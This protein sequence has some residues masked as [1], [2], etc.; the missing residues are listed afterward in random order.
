MTAFRRF[1]IVVA[2]IVQVLS[3]IFCTL[4]GGVFGSASGAFRS[5]LFGV[6]TGGYSGI[7]IDGLGQIASTGAVLGFIIGAIGG[8]VASCTLAGI[9]FTF[10][11][12]ERNT[13]A[14]V[15][16]LS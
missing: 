12:I 16:N 2:E 7:N 14:G 11:Q 1:V 9:V 3:I 8:F 6:A 4:L 10:V 15:E 13:R 5:G